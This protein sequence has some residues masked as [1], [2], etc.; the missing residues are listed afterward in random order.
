MDMSTYLI[1]L[2]YQFSPNYKVKSMQFTWKFQWFF[3]EVEI[4]EVGI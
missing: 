4:L 3:W 2:K 1:M